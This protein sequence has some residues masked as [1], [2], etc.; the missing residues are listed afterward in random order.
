[1]EWVHIAMGLSSAV[2]QQVLAQPK[3]WHE[4]WIPSFIPVVPALIAL[5]GVLVGIK[6]SLR[7]AR[8]ERLESKARD[9]YIEL[10]R[11]Y[12]ELGGACFTFVRSMAHVKRSQDE[13]EE[14][15]KTY[16]GYPKEAQDQARS[17]H[18]SERLKA[19]EHLT[20]SFDNMMVTYSRLRLLETDVHRN[21]QMQ[22]MF[23]AVGSVTLLNVDQVTGDVLSKLDT[24]LTKTAIHLE[25]SYRNALGLAAEGKHPA[26]ASD[27]IGSTERPHRPHPD[28][29]P[30]APPHI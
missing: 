2:L 11:H 29:H 3:P 1:M 5:W 30:E 18:L 23:F 17:V 10:V 21:A 4:V 27:Q 24:F 12:G 26:M 20:R 6:W 9:L 28:G 16:S 14:F 25:E 22:S 19:G 13:I 8:Q 7:R 15:Q